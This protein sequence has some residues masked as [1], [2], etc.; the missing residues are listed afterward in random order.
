ME[1]QVE[2]KMT[3]TVDADQEKVQPE[4]EGDDIR[5]ENSTKSANNSRTALEGK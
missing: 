2:D 4:S 1:G 5:E 3:A